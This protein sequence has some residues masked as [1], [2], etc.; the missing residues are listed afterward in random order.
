MILIFAF[1]YWQ[2]ISYFYKAV[3]KKYMFQAVLQKYIHVKLLLVDKSV[4]I[5]LMYGKGLSAL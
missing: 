5:F 2:I 1:I 3:L 4:V